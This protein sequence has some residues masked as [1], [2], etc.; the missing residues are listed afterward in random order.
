MNTNAFIILLC[1]VSAVTFAKNAHLSD[2][3]ARWRRDLTS[4]EDNTVDNDDAESAEAAEPADGRDCVAACKIDLWGTL[5]TAT[6]QIH[7]NHS[8]AHGPEAP[9]HASY[10]STANTMFSEGEMNAICTPFNRS[11]TCVAGCGEDAYQPP[12]IAAQVRKLLQ[13]VCITHNA[14]IKRHARCMTA[15]INEFGDNPAQL[16]TCNCGGMEKLMKQAEAVQMMP[17]TASA[18]SRAAVRTLAKTC[19][20][21]KCYAGCVATAIDTKCGGTAASTT[22]KHILENF[23]GIAIAT[24]ETMGIPAPTAC[25]VIHS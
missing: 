20:I 3:I 22:F 13:S 7:A 18:D 11:V 12:G 25:L 5:S 2:L 9:R 4:G 23:V 24:V 17:F 15:A 21:A 14:D 1:A 8:V 6:A 10:R 19:K 16:Q